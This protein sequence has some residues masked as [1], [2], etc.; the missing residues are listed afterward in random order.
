M[1]YFGACLAVPSL[2]G[3]SWLLERLFRDEIEQEE[4]QLSQIGYGAGFE[5]NTPR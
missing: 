2:S 5:C 4:Y 3:V 1:A